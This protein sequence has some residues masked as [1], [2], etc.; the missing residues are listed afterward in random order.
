MDSVMAPTSAKLTYASKDSVSRFGE[1]EQSLG[2]AISKVG[3]DDFIDL[4]PDVWK[5]TGPPRVDYWPSRMEDIIRFN[6]V[7]GAFTGVSSVVRFRDM[8]PGLMARAHIGWAWSEQVPRG[9][10]SVSLTRGQWIS[11]ARAQRE[12]ATTND[13]LF[14]L[15]SGLSIGPV[16][17]GTDD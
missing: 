10:A 8:A 9:A 4:A 1:W 13:F 15:E 11:S 12:L 17:S 16:I 3:A 7:E 6:R 14:A 2:G 5:T